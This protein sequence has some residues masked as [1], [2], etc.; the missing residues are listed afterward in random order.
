M[1]ADSTMSPI[2][3]IHVITRLDQ[4]GSARNTMLTVL[5]HDRAHYTPIVIAG[6]P[7]RWTAQG[8]EEATHHNAHRLLSAGVRCL[9]LDTLVRH[10]SP[11]DDLRALWRIWNVFLEERPAVVHTHTS[12]AGAI[13]RVAAWLAGVPTIIHTPHGHVFYGHFG[14]GLSWVFLQLERLLALI[15]THA[16]ALTDAERRDYLD[17]NVGT[18]SLWSVIPSGIDREPFQATATTPKRRPVFFGCP[19]DAVV[20]GSVGWLTEI[21][22]HRTLIE[23]IAEVAPAHPRVHLVLVGTG[24]LHD[25]Y[26]QLAD[27]LGIRDRVHLIGH[28]EDVPACLAGMDIF[29]LPSL[30]EGMG[31]ALVEAM[32][33][34]LPVIATRVGGVPGVLEDRRTGLLVPPADSGALARALVTHLQNPARARDMG[35]AAGLSIGTHYDVAWMVPAIESIYEAV[36]PRPDIRKAPAW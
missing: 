16:I 7:G 34:C 33:A 9:L 20:V 4:G 21:K 24:H 36:R 12:K 26:V 15:T 17:R 28:Q 27:W 5:G 18:P 35:L 8:G 29:V 3:V 13:G 6:K 30:N 2:K 32:A 1:K 23:A 22:G 10:V 14:R 25:D 11:L 19:E 31:R